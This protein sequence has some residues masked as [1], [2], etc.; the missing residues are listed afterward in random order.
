M[1][2]EVLKKHG[3]LPTKMKELMEYHFN[4]VNADLK[5]SITKDNN[6][7]YL[8][9]LVVLAFFHRIVMEDGDTNWENIREALDKIGISYDMFHDAMAYW[10]RQEVVNISHEGKVCEIGDQILAS[11]LFYKLVIEDNQIPLIALFA[12]L[13]S[14]FSTATPFNVVSVYEFSK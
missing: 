13:L 12:F 10:D 6:A 7:N 2:A 4:R 1:M 9:S 8:K 3:H 14:H 11:Y 5:N